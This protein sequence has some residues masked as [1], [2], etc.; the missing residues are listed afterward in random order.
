MWNES[1]VT[2]FEQMKRE[3]KLN[4][5]I[6]ANVDE[7]IA[8]ARIENFFKRYLL[9]VSCDMDQYMAGEQNAQRKVLVTLTKIVLFVVGTKFAVSGL[10]RNLWIRAVTCDSNYLIGHPLFISVMMSICAFCILFIGLTLQYQES[11]GILTVF[12]LLHSIKHKH[13]AN[14]LNDLHYRRLILYSNLV[15]KYFLYQGFWSLVIVTNG[16]MLGATLLAYSDPESGFSMIGVIFWSVLTLIWTIQFYGTVTVLFIVWFMTTFCIKN[17][18]LEINDQIE[19]A[20]RTNDES[21]LMRLINDHHKAERMTEE[22][23]QF[24]CLLI[25]VLYYCGTPALEILIYLSHEPT[26]YLYA[27][28]AAIFIFVIV[29]GVVFLVNF[30]SA[31][32]SKAAKKS[33]PALYT[34]VSRISRTRPANWKVVNFIEALS[35]NDIGFYCNDMFP[36]NNYEFYQYL[37]ITGLNYFLI[38]DLKSR[39]QL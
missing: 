33:Y 28:F 14:Q 22:L 20:L 1:I 37:Y 12:Q 11:T 7:K 10:S 26:T 6:N 23:N 24:F 5:F 15:T 19:L 3:S 16:F 30:M 18:F 4:K 2:V 39:F 17:Q 9:A 8:I 36:M 29:F 38:L 21:H 13:L 25:F 27:R 35:G 34:Y 31:Q 32:I